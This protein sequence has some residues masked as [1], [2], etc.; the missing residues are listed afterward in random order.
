[1]VSRGVL[2][3]VFED[4]GQQGLGVYSVALAFVVELESV[5]Q[6]RSQHCAQVVETDIVA[7][8]QKRVTLGSKDQGLRSAR[9]DAEA[10]ISFHV[11]RDL[12]SI[13]LRAPDETS[14]RA[15]NVGSDWHQ[16]NE[17]LSA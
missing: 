6:G 8:L 12:G 13:M 16:A 5:A 10:D 2:D 15:A 14:D 9:A 4:S 3:R 1:M 11:G 7:V 17:P